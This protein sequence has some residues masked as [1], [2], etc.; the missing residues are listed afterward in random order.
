MRVTIRKLVRISSP[1]GG[2]RLIALIAL[3][4]FAA[5]MQSVGIAS[6][7]PFLAVIG[8]PELIRANAVLSYCY[9]YFGFES[10][11]RFLFFLGVA[12]F[13]AFVSGTI[14]VIITDWSVAMYGAQQQYQLSRRLM[15]G[16]L[17]RPYEFF[18]AN[19]SSELSKTVLQEVSLAINGALV[20]MMRLLRQVLSAATI[21]AVL[22]AVSPSLA[23][24][25]ATSLAV[26]YALIYVVV[27]RWLNRVGHER[28]EAQRARFVSVAEAF[29][30]QKEIRLLGRGAEYVERFKRPSL[31]LV[32]INAKS[33]VLMSLPQNGIEAIAFGGILLIVLSLLAGEGSLGSILPILGVYAL[34][35][36]KLIPAFQQIFAAIAQ[37]RLNMPTVDLLLNCLKEG[38]FINEPAPDQDD[39]V[40]LEPRVCVSIDQV[41]YG[42]P[43]AEKDALNG[44]SLD[45]PV[46]ST[47]GIVGPSGSGKSTL[48]DILL[49]L[50]RPQAGSLR[51]DDTEISV[52]NT[53]EWQ[54]C[55]GYVPQ[56]IFLA[57]QNIAAN[58]ALGVPE[59]KIDMDRVI[60]A[61]KL[62]HLHK[63]VT[64]ELPEAYETQIGERGMRLS[65]G[66]RQRIGIARALYRDPPILLF[67][68]ATSALDNATERALMESINELSGR[69]TIV[70][71]AH[72]L[73]TVQACDTIYLLSNGRVLEQ[74]HWNELN[75]EG[76]HFTALASG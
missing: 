25:V 8:D 76:T 26:V 3:M 54:A 55:V 14:V 2:A 44:V 60:E 10:D 36:K 20:P 29:T 33:S 69:R 50:L 13:V 28:I 38:D 47:I 12:S 4:V 51:V 70:L 68:E 71:I 57:D 59:E 42:Y 72:R 63:F 52:D 16:Y 66:Q 58:I 30:G 34:A 11:S 18:L 15:Q 32:S 45:I 53:S 74:G 5:I 19:N 41:H 48:I 49:G 43:G 17:A 35:G 64:D 62:A 39:V 67:D 65:G 24:T 61:A 31:R 75:Q 7:M 27:R 1:G 37:I 46:N 73:S 6:V 40:P 9:E 56:H 21:V 22:V 23:F